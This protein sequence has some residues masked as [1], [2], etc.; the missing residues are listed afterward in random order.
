MDDRGGAGADMPTMKAGQNLLFELVSDP[1]K[2]P[3][4]RAYRLDMIVWSAGSC[5]VCRH[6]R[7]ARALRAVLPFKNLVR[8]RVRS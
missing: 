1:R 7:R 8:L 4:A 2:Q 3:A 5:H 6:D